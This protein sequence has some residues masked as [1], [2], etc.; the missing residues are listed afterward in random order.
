MTA[1]TYAQLG[2]AAAY[3]VD[4]RLSQENLKGR[5]LTALAR[6]PLTN[7]EVREITQLSRQQVTRLLGQLRE[8]RLVRVSGSTKGSRWSLVGNPKHR[9]HD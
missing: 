8:E 3:H 4:A 1:A 6:T 5:I 2:E 9:V 7:A